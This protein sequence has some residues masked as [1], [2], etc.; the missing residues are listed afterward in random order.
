VRHE[1]F[2]RN[3]NSPLEERITLE[4]RGSATV[5]IADLGFGFQKRLGS[6]T[7]ARRWVAVPFRRQVDGKVHD[8]SSQDLTAAHFSNSGWAN[9]ASVAEQEIVDQNKLRLEAWAWTDR[10]HGLLVAKYNPDHIEYSIASVE[11][12]GGGPFLRFGGAGLALYREPQVATSIAPGKRVSFGVT[13]Y[14]VFDGDWPEAYELYRTFLDQQGHGLPPDYDPPL[15]WNELFDVGWYHSNSE[16]LFQHYTREAL[17]REAAKARDMGCDL[18]YLDPGW[19]ICEGTTLWDERRLGKVADF[20]RELRER[21]GL[22]LGYRT[23]GRVYREEFPK[24][25]YLRRQREKGDYCRPILSA[26]LPTEPVPLATPDGRPNLALLPEAK[27]KASSVIAGFPELHTVEHLNDGYYN[28]AASWASAQ[29]PSWVEID[30]GAVYSIDEI[31]LGSEHRVQFNDRAITKFEVRVATQ[32]AKDNDSGFWQKV[33]AYDGEPIHATRSF[34]F[35]PVSARWVRVLI[36]VAEDSTA[37][38]DELEIYETRPHVGGPVPVRRAPP[39]TP[40]GA[41]LGFWEVCTQCRDWQQEKLKR[42]LAVTS[43]GVDF[44]MFDE[45]DWRGPCYDPR[46]GHPVPSTPEGHVRAVY[47][48]VEKLRQKYPGVLVEAHDPVWPWSARYLP[49]YFRQGF[50]RNHYQENWGFEFMWNPIEDLRSGRALCLYYYNLGCS[51][52]LYDHITMEGDNDACLAFWW[53]ASTVRHLGIGGKKSLNSAKENEPR[54]AAYK[55]AVGEYNQLRPFY[56]RGQFIGVDETTHVHLHPAKSA[57]VVNVFNLTTAPVRREVKLQ[58]GSLR[59][60]NFDRFEVQGARWRLEHG[61]LI[62]IFDLSPLSPAH[63]VL[64]DSALQ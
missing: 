6:D 34:A 30:L 5:E 57:A 22:K 60:R 14:Q 21:F 40:A 28:N 62:L 18:L 31:A 25:W 56:A 63:A 41:P 13:R 20:S 55:Q 4:N 29:D 64:R 16:Q 37:R 58:P 32:Y 45:F 2:F 49:V 1:L 11:R 50:T 17:L 24:T 10:Q 39:Q 59:W 36:R 52:P 33:L 19:E 38:I 51:I 9:D 53:Y 46:H 23:I 35:N 3:S 47:G 42:I 12:E 15:N 44:M 7:T 61:T 48:L 27:A 8:Y 43:G 26:Q 54:Y